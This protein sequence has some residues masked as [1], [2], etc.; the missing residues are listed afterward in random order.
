[1][2]GFDSPS[3]LKVELTTIKFPIYF[4]NFFW[5]GGRAVECTGLENLH[6]RN[7]IASSNL[8]LSAKIE[9]S[10]EMLQL[11]IFVLLWF[12]EKSPKKH[13]LNQYPVMRLFQIFHQ[14]QVL[15]FNPYKQ[16]LLKSRVLLFPLSKWDDL[17][18]VFLMASILQYI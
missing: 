12:V 13:F 2:R 3:H 16:R 9:K 5:R 18:A 1:M 4:I 14:T 7:V 10:V 8:A 15:I 6:G 17:L 11:L